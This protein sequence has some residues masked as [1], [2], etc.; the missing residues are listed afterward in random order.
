MR[1]LIVRVLKGAGLYNFLLN[2]KRAF[3]KRKFEETERR[4]AGK[5]LPFYSQFLSPGDLVFDVGANAGNRT[6][7]FLEIGAR[8][9]AV[10]P[11]FDCIEILKKKF[12]DKIVIETV[13]LG[14]SPGEMEMYIA[15]ETTIST[16]SKEFIDKTKDNKFSRNRW[17]RKIK[18]PIATLDQLIGSHGRPEFCKIDVEG[19][20]TEVLK[21]LSVPINKISF[22]YN[23]PELADNVKKNIALLNGLSTGYVFNYS[24]GETMQLE[25]D[26]WKTAAEFSEWIQKP[27][28]LDSDFGDIYAFL[29]KQS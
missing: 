28:F 21:G 22:E 8:V 27:Q 25:L 2:L 23:V 16:F 3:N 10:E 4:N 24:I 15:D 17:E 9:I 26:K 20:E 19:F 14:S 6:S 13:G 5:R 7:V 18:V 1:K 11:Q 12:G 29:Q